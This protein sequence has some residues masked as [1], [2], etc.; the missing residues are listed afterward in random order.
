MT[1]QNTLTVECH[2]NRQEDQLFL[3]LCCSHKKLAAKPVKNDEQT[4]SLQWPGNRVIGAAAI[5]LYLEASIPEPSLF[6]NGNI[7]MPVAL[8]HWRQ[9]MMAIPT[10]N[11]T[12]LTANG[13][14]ISRQMED[15]RPFLQGPSPGLADICAASWCIPHRNLFTDHETLLPWIER[16]QALTNRQSGQTAINLATADALHENVTYRGLLEC[17]I[18][19]GVT[20]VTS[21]LDD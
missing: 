18:V 20:T 15:G 17:T 19:D 13:L 21:P 1:P 2:T 7:G 8:L 11:E 12:A 10:T 3:E 4:F 9:S 14:L 5:C 6:P 16:M